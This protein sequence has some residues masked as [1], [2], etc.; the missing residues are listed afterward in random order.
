MR[1]SNC[2]PLCRPLPLGH[3]VVLFGLLLLTGYIASERS[4]GA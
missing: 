1:I 4:F 3:V 2:L